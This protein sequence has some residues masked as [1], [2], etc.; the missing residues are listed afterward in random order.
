MRRLFAVLTVLMSCSAVLLGQRTVPGAVAEIHGQV[1]FSE[2]HQASNGVLVT[3]EG[4]GSGLFRQVQTDDRGKFEF[5][6][7]VPERYKVKARFPGYHLHR[8]C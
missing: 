2:G 3:L 1:V 5:S 8:P 4:A 6:G 7:L